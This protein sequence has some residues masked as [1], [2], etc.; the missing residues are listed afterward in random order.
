MPTQSGK[1]TKSFTIFD[2]DLSDKFQVL[3]RV[4]TSVACRAYIIYKVN[5]IQTYSNGS[6]F[7]GEMRNAHD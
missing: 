5:D 6:R 7:I 4:G 2:G 3:R 1:G